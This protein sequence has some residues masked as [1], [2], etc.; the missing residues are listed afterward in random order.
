MAENPNDDRNINPE[1]RL[2][3]EQANP[4]VKL[5]GLEGKTS[6]I[7]Y[8]LSI[9]AQLSVLS[10]G[11][12]LGASSGALL[13]VKDAMHLSTTWQ[14]LVM[15]GPLPIAVIISIIAAKISDKF[16]RRKTIMASSVSYLVGSIVTG[17]AVNQYMLL[18]GRFMV[19]FGFGFTGASTA[20]YIAEC[21]PV[22]MRGKLI[23]LSQ[24]FLTVGI[25]SATIFAGVFSYDT[26]NGWRY[27]WA[28]QGIWSVIQFTGLLFMPESPRWL[29]QKSK[30][31]EGKAAL[32]KLRNGVNIEEE[33]NEIKKNCEEDMK[34]SENLGEIFVDFFFQFSFLRFF[35]I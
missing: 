20:V 7:I 9:I 29:I 34:N 4:N 6:F 13:L 21:A 24:P 27:M 22:R 2:C 19:G 33:F 28:F 31:S 32:A 14:Q 30:F 8:L 12:D 3:Q 1:N 16:G 25:L 15:A 35:R 10:V 18:C 23:G 11:Y 5:L 17:S 26:I